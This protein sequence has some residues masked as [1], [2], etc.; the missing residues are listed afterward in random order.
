MPSYQAN[1]PVKATQITLRIV[2][3]LQR[4]D[5][6]GVTAIAQELD[7]SKSSAHDY[8]STLRESGYVVKQDS[9]Y[10]VG[11][12]FLDL[13]AHARQKRKIYSEAKNEVDELADE[14]GEFA[15]LM[16]EE[17][18]LGIY[19]HRGVG[20]RAV[21]VDVHVGR[22][23]HLHNTALGKALLAHMSEERVAEIIDEHG[24]PS[25]TDQT[26]TDRDHLR[27][28]LDEITNQGVAFDDEER[29]SGLRC[30]AVPILDQDDCAVGAISISGPTSRMTETRYQEE[31]PARLQQSANVI[32]LNV[33]FS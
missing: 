31:L 1:S 9:E 17:H 27:E 5:G 23:V 20:E 26:I 11:L 15:N 25:T 28:E 6:A 29:L 32:E 2:E 7:I 10:S 22:Q 21:N 8:L 24:L 30:V 4:L 33:N 16:V 14:T 12:R 18:G 3:T 13:G 19:L